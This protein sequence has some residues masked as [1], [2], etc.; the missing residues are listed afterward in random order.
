MKKLILTSTAVLILTIAHGQINPSVTC[1]G[2]SCFGDCNGTA[3][4]NPTGG[5]PPYTYSWAPGGQTTQMITGLCN[6]LYCCSVSDASGPPALT[7]CCSI[8][9][10]QLIQTNVSTTSPSCSSC[11]D[12][13]ATVNPSGGSPPYTYSWSVA[14]PQITQTI[15]GLCAGTYSVCVTDGNGCSNCQSF[16]VT[17]PTGIN[18]VIK[19]NSLTISPNPFSVQTVLRTDHPLINATL[20]V[21]NC[22]GQTV[23]QIKNINGRTVTLSRDNLASGLYF[24]RLTEENKTIAVDKLVI[25]DK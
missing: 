2:N 14:P 13:T 1:T 8:T 3:T 20:T 24:V 21:D 15:T 18:E 10:P 5:T 11:C 9:S 7:T 23:A 17:A 12:G 16:I 19:N 4:A 22:F 25:S 6:G